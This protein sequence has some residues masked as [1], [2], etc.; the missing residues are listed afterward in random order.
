[1]EVR[2]EMYVN[3]TANIWSGRTS[4]E[5]FFWK[6]AELDGNQLKYVDGSSGS[7]LR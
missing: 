7:R 2:G 5:G 4:V 3:V 6:L 1:M